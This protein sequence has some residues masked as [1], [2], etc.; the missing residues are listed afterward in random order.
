LVQARAEETRRRILDAAV[1]IFGEVGYGDAVLSDVLERAEVTKG[2]FYH[3]FHTKEALA[4]ALIELA[5]RKIQ[6]AFDQALSSA[7]SPTLE[8]LIRAAFISTDIAETDRRVRIGNALR[9]ALSQIS[10]KAAS[11]YLARR[12]DIFAAVTRSVADGD[13][14]DDIDVD[15]AV[16]GIYAGLLGTRT[17]CDA[18]GDD[19]FLRTGQLLSVMLAAI[20]PASKLPY[21]QEFLSRT[22]RQYTAAGVDGAD[23]VEA[24]VP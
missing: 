24:I 10:P 23:L 5:D 2:A 17:L 16:H 21:F 18:S 15:A 14:R 6:D 22:M 7:S 12:N 13:V 4:A 1:D 20:V 19:V 8:N 9:Q 3:H 11:T